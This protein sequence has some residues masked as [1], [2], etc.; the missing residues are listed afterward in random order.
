METKKVLDP[1]KVCHLDKHRQTHTHPKPTCVCLCL[2]M[3]SQSNSKQKNC[4]KI[5]RKCVL[6]GGGKECFKRTSKQTF[7]ACLLE[8]DRKQTHW[9]KEEERVK[10][11]EIKLGFRQ[12]NSYIDKL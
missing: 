3:K 12:S 1:K 4:R 2:Y 8:I 10:R 6:K 7:S 5:E 9:K 11:K